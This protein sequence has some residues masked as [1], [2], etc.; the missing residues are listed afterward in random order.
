MILNTGSELNMRS[1][2]INQH[3]CRNLISFGNQGKNL[4]ARILKAQG[5]DSAANDATDSYQG[6]LVNAI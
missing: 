5:G 6:M 1:I 3:R 4:V 2:Q